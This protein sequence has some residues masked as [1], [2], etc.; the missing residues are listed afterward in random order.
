MSYTLA[1]TAM[2]RGSHP[3]KGAYLRECRKVVPALIVHCDQVVQG[4]REIL[5]Q[6][7]PETT[8][9]QARSV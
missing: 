3:A 9:L 7:T 5:E 8:D 2:T 4:L 1:I 6:E